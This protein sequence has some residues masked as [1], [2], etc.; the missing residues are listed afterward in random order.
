MR[1]LWGARVLNH[2]QC[3]DKYEFQVY[4]AIQTYTA[5]LIEAFTALPL[6]YPQVIVQSKHI[7]FKVR[8]LDNIAILKYNMDNMP[9]VQ[10]GKSAKSTTC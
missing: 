1:C 10:H 2:F 8:S 3:K 6:L 5:P 9:K 7:L 4:K